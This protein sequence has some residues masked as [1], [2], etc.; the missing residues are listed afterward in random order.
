MSSEAE[1]PVSVYQNF[2]VLTAQEWGEISA[3]PRW[4]EKRSEGEGR[5]RDPGK[6][7]AGN[8]RVVSKRTVSSIFHPW[9]EHVKLRFYGF[10]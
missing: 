8:Q 9:T 2:N 5:W 4:G 3:S 1:L 7:Q 10:F 6:T